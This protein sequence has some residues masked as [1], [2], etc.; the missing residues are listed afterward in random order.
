ML[1][2]CKSI[3][4]ILPC[5]LGFNTEGSELTVG[6]WAFGRLEFREDEDRVELYSC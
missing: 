5:K 3:F 1:N 2:W 4:V 6:H